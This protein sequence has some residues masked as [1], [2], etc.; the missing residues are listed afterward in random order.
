MRCAKPLTPDTQEGQIKKHTKKVIV[1][2]TNC[3]EKD[4]IGQIVN[5]GVY[6][7]LKINFPELSLSI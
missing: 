6:K 5:Q 7:F 3:A 1:S 2:V 4:K